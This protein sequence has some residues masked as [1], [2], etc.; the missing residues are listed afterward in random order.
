MFKKGDI[1][2][3]KTGPD[4]ELGKY[5]SGIGV[6]VG[7]VWRNDQ[8]CYKIDKSTKHNRWHVLARQAVK[9]RQNIRMYE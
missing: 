4:F 5:G 9:M 7:I 2:E 1:V 6:V 3:V 8:W